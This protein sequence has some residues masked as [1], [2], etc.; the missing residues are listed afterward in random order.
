MRTTLGEWMQ[1]WLEGYVRLCCAP[2]TYEGYERNIRCHINPALGLIMLSELRP[3]HLD[4]FYS[5]LLKEGRIDGKGGLA[6]QSVLHIH[7]ILSEALTFAVKRG[8]LFRN[9]A[10]LVDPPRVSQFDRKTLTPEE[11][12][13][14][15]EAAR[16]SPYFPAINMGEKTGMRQGEILG[17]RWR[18]VDF[19]QK[20]VSVVQVLHKR[21]GVCY[22][23]EPKSRSSRRRI[24]TQPSLVKFLQWHRAEME[25]INLLLGRTLT[26]DDLVFAKPDGSPLD[27]STLQHAFRRIVRAAGL[28]GIRFHDL[29]H[30]HASLLLMAGVHPKIVQERLGHSTVAITLDLYSHTVSSLQMAAACH[31]DEMM[32]AFQGAEKNVG[33]MSAENEDPKLEN[34]ANGQIRTG[35]RRF[36]KLAPAK[37]P[38]FV[39]KSACLKAYRPPVFTLPRS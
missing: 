35:D 22:F 6:G 2:R 8:L 7:R 17:L 39:A 31:Y 36:T 1:Q 28:E 11:V 4:V 26:P 23:R 18:D 15:L 3:E 19:E 13:R 9:I 33:R 16:G 30:T 25:G 32:E 12:M 5:S 27:P 10:D 20:S 21:R 34:G 24:A 14:L 29:R 38:Q 37:F